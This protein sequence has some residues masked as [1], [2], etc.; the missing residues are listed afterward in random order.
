MEILQA[1]TRVTRE[2][3]AEVSR[4]LPLGPQTHAGV[5]TRVDPH[6]EHLVQ[7][8][9]VLRERQTRAGHVETPYARDLF[10]DLFDARVPV[11]VEVRA[12]SGQ[13]S[14]VVLAKVLLV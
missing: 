6:P 7:L 3:L 8:Q 4:L 11:P 1:E 10:T 14:C 13:R 12:P 9:P 5:A 2:A